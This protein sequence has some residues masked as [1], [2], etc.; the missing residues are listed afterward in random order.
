MELAKKTVIGV[1]CGYL[2]YKSLMAITKAPP[3]KHYINLQ[4]KYPDL[5]VTDA[6]D[7]TLGLQVYAARFPREHGDVMRGMDK[8]AYMYCKHLKE[9][10]LGTCV[11]KYAAK[12]IQQSSSVMT[13]LERLQRQCLVSGVSNETF[14]ETALPLIEVLRNWQHNLATM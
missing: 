9:V 8:A 3:S 11:Q 10:A 12:C 5:V 14:T 1:A 13:Y 6:L 7:S 2:G 4:E